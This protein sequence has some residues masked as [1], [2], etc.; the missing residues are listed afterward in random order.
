MTDDLDE[1]IDLDNL[2]VSTFDG[3]NI[4]N[5]QYPLEVKDRKVHNFDTNK[6]QVELTYRVL[7]GEHEN[8]LI[9][10]RYWTKHPNAEALRIGREQLGA[11]AKALGLSGEL[12]KLDTLLNI[13]FIGKVGVEKKA[14]G[15]EYEPRNEVKGWKPYANP[16]APARAASSRPT[17]S[18]S[19]PA[20][21][22]AV[23]GRAA[24]APAASGGSAI[25]QMRAARRAEAAAAAAAA[26]RELERIDDDIPF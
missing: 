13:P 15:S 6:Q 26:Q 23:A 4:P 9:W 17:A 1:G 14:E 8:R 19:P 16:T 5:G 3:G 10:G 2:P 7:D 20:R 21:T 22:G 24:A 11:L 12:K 25:D 18:A